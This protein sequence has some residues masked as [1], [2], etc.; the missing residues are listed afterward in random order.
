M[1]GVV[2][3]LLPVDYAAPYGRRP[4]GFALLAVSLARTSTA[5]LEDWILH[6][7][8]GHKFGA[9]LRPKVY[10]IHVRKSGLC[11]SPNECSLPLHIRVWPVPKVTLSS[12]CPR[13][14]TTLP[15]K[16]APVS[17]SARA[18]NGWD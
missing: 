15:V 7:G 16:Y 17:G 10:V 6:L 12:T 4:Y 1:P 3:M 2:V 13:T 14:I 11:H 8:S 9:W 5:S 18:R